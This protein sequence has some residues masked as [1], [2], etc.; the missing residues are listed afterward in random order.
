MVG[1]VGVG[2]SVTGQGHLHTKRGALTERNG[3]REY[4][5]ITNAC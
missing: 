4:V 2:V 1:V 5:G 3:G